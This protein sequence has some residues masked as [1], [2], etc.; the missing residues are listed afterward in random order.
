VSCIVRWIL[1]VNMANVA[2]QTKSQ[3]LY[4]LEVEVTPASGRGE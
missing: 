1:C 3:P 4:R 2:L